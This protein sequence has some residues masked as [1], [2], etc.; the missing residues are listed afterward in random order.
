MSTVTDTNKVFNQNTNL[1]GN[2]L[3]NSATKARA[4]R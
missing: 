4:P 1:A 3:H 2:I